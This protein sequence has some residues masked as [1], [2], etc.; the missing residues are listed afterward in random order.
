[1]NV[2]EFSL[3]RTTRTRPAKLLLDAPGRNEGRPVV[4]VPLAAIH[5]YSPYPACHAR[6]ALIKSPGFPI[7]SFHCFDRMNL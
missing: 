6:D 5:F 1:M 2:E 4:F 7:L 3:P